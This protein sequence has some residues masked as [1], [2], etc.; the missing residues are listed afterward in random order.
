MIIDTIGLRGLL[1][2]GP[3]SEPLAMK[4]LNVLIGPN[5]S[6][7]SNMIE[8]ISLLQA[9]PRYLAAAIREG[10]QTGDL[11][12]N[13]DESQAQ[14]VIAVVIQGP[15]EYYSYCLEIGIG[16]LG[17]TGYRIIDEFIAALPE[18]EEHK[19]LLFEKWN[20][21]SDSGF[22]RSVEVKSKREKLDPGQSALSQLKGPQYFYGLT[23]I[24]YVFGRIKIYRDWYFGRHTPPR[25]PQR[26]D[27]PSNFLLEDCSNLGLV[28]NQFDQYPKAK[29][30][31]LEAMR[32]LYE[33]IN[34]YKTIIKGDDT[35]QVFMQE[36]QKAP[37]VPATQLSDGTLR[38]LCLLA[39]LCHPHPPPLIC[40]EEPELGLHPD[41]LPTIADLLVEASK[42]CQLIITTHSEI[43]VDSLTHTPE[44]IVVCEK[45][46]GQTTMRRLD[47]DKLAKWL[48]KYRLGE[49]W[50]SGELG[51]NRW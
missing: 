10:G 11:F 21:S 15:Y 26:V 29:A 46:D 3:E 6:G 28:L 31:L 18:G 16:G 50:T 19:S 34:D 48:E 41:I 27:L 36:G 13:G 25:I 47:K 20:T 39:I 40:I 33:D 38:Y 2:F 23:H 4:P 5:G 7:K 43:L 44:S 14:A 17:S 37:P 35:I 32:E 24:S 22:D 49:L 9:A 12:W 51:G 30:R 8:A 1:S 42:R 45:H